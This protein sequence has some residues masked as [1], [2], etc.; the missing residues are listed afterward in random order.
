MVIVDSSVWIGF[1]S[2]IP[3]DQVSLLEKMLSDGTPLFMIPLVY[4]EVLQGIRSDREFQLVKQ[5]FDELLFI[6]LNQKELALKAATIYRT[7]RQSGVTI[8]K[9]A[10]CIIAATSLLSGIPLLYL[11]RDFN[12][13]AGIF[14]AIRVT[15]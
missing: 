13:I 2:G 14:P 15:T 7:C 10:D 12:L 8:R 9:S 5:R 1:F 6:E 4:Q 3:S 11:D